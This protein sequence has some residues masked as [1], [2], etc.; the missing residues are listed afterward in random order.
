MSSSCLMSTDCMP[1]T[2]HAS[3]QNNLIC[4]HLY[5]HVINEETWHSERLRNKLKVGNTAIAMIPNI[6][7]QGHTLRT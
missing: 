5:S 6:L 1:G 3:S 2:V 4:A 7:C